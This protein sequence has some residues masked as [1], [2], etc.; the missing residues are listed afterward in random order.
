MVTDPELHAAQPE[1]KKEEED[2]GDQMTNGCAML[3]T[4]KGKEAVE[5]II[6]ESPAGLTHF[7]KNEV[8]LSIYQNKKI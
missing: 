1:E 6:E 5:K 4:P 7:S 3:E 2:D 8:N